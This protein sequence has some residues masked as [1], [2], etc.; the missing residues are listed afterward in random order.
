MLKFNNPHLTSGKKELAKSMEQEK[1]EVQSVENM[2]CFCFSKLQNV[3]YKVVPVAGHAK[4]GVRENRGSSSRVLQSQECF[5][6][7]REMKGFSS[8]MLQI[9]C[10]KKW[11]GSENI[12]KKFELQRVDANRNT[13]PNQ[14][15]NS[16]R[17][18][19]AR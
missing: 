4:K 19:H 5:K 2:M 6:I 1:F 3:E 18:M 13:M 11:F 17:T 16:N 10:K 14:S 15:L 12:N 7:Q 9:P 8:R